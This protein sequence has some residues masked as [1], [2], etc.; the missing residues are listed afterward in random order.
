MPNRNPAFADFSFLFFTVT[1]PPQ[2]TS[3]SS[4]NNCYVSMAVHYLFIV[5]APSWQYFIAQFLQQ[6]FTVV[7]HLEKLLTKQHKK[8]RKMSVLT[9]GG[10]LPSEQANQRKVEENQ[11]INY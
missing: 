7:I 10:C 4:T 6:Q 8:Q 5:S 1:S 11:S 2:N 3:I 9:Y